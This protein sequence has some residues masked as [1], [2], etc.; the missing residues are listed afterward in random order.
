MPVVEVEDVDRPPICPQRLESGATE[1]PEPPRVV[2]VV[3]VRVAVEAIAIEGSRMVDQSQSV[4]I[5]GHIEHGHRADPD[6]ARGS[7]TRNASVRSI[8]AGSGTPR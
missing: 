3:A 6:G 8:R 1:Q 4:A 5:G 2:R 7:G